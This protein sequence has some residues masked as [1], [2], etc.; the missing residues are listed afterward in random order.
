VIPGLRLIRNEPCHVH[1]SSSNPPQ[2]FHLGTC[3]SRFVSY[4]RGFADASQTSEPLLGHSQTGP[5]ISEFRRKG[6]NFLSFL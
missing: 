6:S 1:A 2:I 4:L 3:V 5:L